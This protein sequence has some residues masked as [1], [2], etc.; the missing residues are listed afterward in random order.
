M[1]RLGVLSRQLLAAQVVEAGTTPSAEDLG[2]GSLWTEKIGQ[3]PPMG[4]F[5]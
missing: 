5:R 3:A 1:R 2:G 4:A